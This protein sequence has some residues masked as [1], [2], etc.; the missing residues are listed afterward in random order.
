MGE[1]QSDFSAG[2]MCEITGCSSAATTT[3]WLIDEERHLAVCWKHAE[4]P[5]EPDKAD[6]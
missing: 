1:T 6:H 3:R 2:S 5:E 4:S